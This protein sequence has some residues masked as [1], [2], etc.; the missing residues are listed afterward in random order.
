MPAVGRPYHRAAVFVGRMAERSRVADLLAAARDGRA[1]PLLVHGEAGI[2]KSALL[3]EVC[4]AADSWSV[5][6][7]R[8]SRAEADLPYGGLQQLLA[9]VLAGLEVIPALQADALRGALGLAAPQPDARLAVLAGTLGLLVASAQEQPV[10]LAV[11]DADQ[12]DAA[13]ADALGFLARRLHVGR[14]ALVATARSDRRDGLDDHAFD[15]LRLA[16]LTLEEARELLA[17]RVASDEVVEQ[18]W[19]ETG[20][21]PLALASLPERL[22]A[23]ERSGHEPIVGPLPAATRVRR[24]Y[25]SRIVALPE[26]T[27]RA[28]LVAA[29]GGEASMATINDAVAAIGADPARLAAAEQAGIVTIRDG[30]IEFRDPLLRSAVYHDAAPDDRRAA[31]DA[32]AGA[33]AEERDADRRAWHRASAAATPDEEV[34]RAL[35]QAALRARRRGGVAVEAMALA[36]AA[37]LTPQ[38]EPRAARLL[39][40]ARSTRR[41]GRLPQA[42]ALL[43]EAA[44]LAHAPGLASELALERARLTAASGADAAAGELLRR[45]ADEAAARDG[46]QAA[47]LLVADVVLMLDA[48]EVAA[49]ATSAARAVDLAADGSARELGAQAHEGIALARGDPLALDALRAGAADGA[50]DDEDP[51]LGAWPA[52][53][54]ALA[55]ER[56]Q[57]RALL[58]RL[59]D[60]HRVSGDLWSLAEDL[61]ALAGLELLAGRLSPALE[62]VREALQLADDLAW[63]R[64]RRRALCLLALV[65]CEL[66]REVDCR[67]HADEGRELALAHGAADGLAAAGLA[68]GRLELASRRPEQAIAA[69]EP[70]RRAARQAGIV[71]PDWLPWAAPLIEAF[72]AAGRDDDAREELARLEAAAATSAQRAAAARCAGLLAGRDAFSAHFERALALHE[73]DGNA[74][75]RGRTRLAF[76]QRELATGAVARARELLRDALDDLELAGAAAWSEHARAA[77]AECGEVARRQAPRAIDL[78]TPQ[79]L[80]VVR[81]VAE[82]ATNRDVAARLFLSQKT[83]EYHL[84]NTFRKLAVRSRTEL[85]ARLAAEGGLAAEHRS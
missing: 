82:G 35:E 50:G 14:I 70:V 8:G 66:G 24:L 16:G 58:A 64:A 11:D 76:G 67:A 7:A 60:R 41:A 69:L 30:A 12:L 46:D 43:E 73:Q 47:T 6:A 38:D 27:R 49:A 26:E 2:G 5:L 71:A 77:L 83:V 72:C 39:A 74:Y 31:H 85:V 65:E 40:A 61:E 84:R 18:L 9:P 21:N 3:T 36:R 78:L 62:A 32:L 23:E 17:G 25:E 51:P 48:H 20:G 15:E 29:A 10:L 54:L 81:L 22:G 13:S 79:E 33:L 1:R 28:L 34:A 44:A 63:P 37:R 42:A 55:G 57:A 45:A 80:Q 4:A 52:R 68:L 59:A 19:R 56:E 53:L 75:E